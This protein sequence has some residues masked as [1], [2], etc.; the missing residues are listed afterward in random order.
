MNREQTRVVRATAR[1]SR[2]SLKVAGNPGR[3]AMRERRNAN[4]GR[5]ARSAPKL[6]VARRFDGGVHRLVR[7]LAAVAGHPAPL[8]EQR[9]KKE[10]VKG[11]SPM[12]R[13]QAM[14]SKGASV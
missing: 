10:V 11:G 13:R 5:P 2:R 3:E 8:V 14:Y 9:I 12:K 6:R 4:G 7:V 1:S